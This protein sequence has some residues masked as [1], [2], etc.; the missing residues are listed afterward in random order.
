MSAVSFVMR[1]S[2]FKTLT[3]A[4]S[5]SFEILLKISSQKGDPELT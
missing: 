1:G 4:L 5:L 3:L 2:Q